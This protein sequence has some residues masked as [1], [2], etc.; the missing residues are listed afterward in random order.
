M[1]LY[2]SV[3]QL[4]IISTFKLENLEEGIIKGSLSKGMGVK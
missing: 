4:E 3:S 1:F 2:L